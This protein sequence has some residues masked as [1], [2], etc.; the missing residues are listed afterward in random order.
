MVKWT[1]LLQNMGEG[2]YCSVFFYINNSLS[3]KTAAWKAS[4][5]L[6]DVL[7][8]YFYS[9]FTRESLEV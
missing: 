7:F 9:I 4:G 6:P 5:F 2:L 1:V 3:G 8:F